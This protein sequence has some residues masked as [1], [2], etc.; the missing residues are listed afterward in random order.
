MEDTEG[1]LR[2]DKN[3]IKTGYKFRM[4]ANGR[5]EKGEGWTLSHLLLPQKLTQPVT[6]P[7]GTDRSDTRPRFAGCFPVIS[8]TNTW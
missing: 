8:R 5:R 3:N 6:H 4:Y 7:K 1:I 2:S